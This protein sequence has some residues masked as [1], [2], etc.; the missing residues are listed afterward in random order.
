MHDMAVGPG[1]HSKMNRHFL[2][3]FTDHAFGGLV[4]TLA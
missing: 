3:V 2:N 1:E 4:F